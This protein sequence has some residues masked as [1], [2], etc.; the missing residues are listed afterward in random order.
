MKYKTILFDLDGTLTDPGV[1]ITSGV[2][3][4][5]EHFDIHV[6]DRR[7]LYKFI[8][9]P[10]YGA[11]TEFYGLSDAQDR[12]AVRLYRDYYARQGLLENEVYPGI[13]E[14]LAAL[15]AAGRRLLVATS[16]PEEFSV[17]ILEHFGLAQYFDFIAGSAFD[18][19]RDSK[20]AVIAYGRAH[21]GFDPAEAVMVGDRKYDVLGAAACGLPCIGVLYGYG[22]QAEL[23]SAG[24]AD[25]AETVSALRQILLGS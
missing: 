1:G 16:K 24:A 13:P 25:I 7:E 14:L 8:G 5:L 23:V 11:F 18:G 9:P 10:L 3:C 12:E 21:T 4:A 17:Q 6:E 20:A 2:M 22:S 15:K 19:S